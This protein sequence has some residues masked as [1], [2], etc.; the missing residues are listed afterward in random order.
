M[1]IPTLTTER[2]VLRAL[3]GEDFP[4]WAAMNADPEFARVFGY[5]APL[6]AEEAWRALALQIGHWTLRGFGMWA[7]AEHATPRRFLGRI[8]FFQPE[9]WPGFELGWALAP[10]VWGRGYATEGA[11]AALRFAFTTLDRPRVLSLVSPQ[12]IRSAGVARRIG[13]QIVDRIELRGKP[14]DVWAIDRSTWLA[15]R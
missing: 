15:R 8:G 1:E 10:E 12:N 4:A 2:L 9:G 14:A 7:V 6:S 13:E 3:D 5:P 11:L